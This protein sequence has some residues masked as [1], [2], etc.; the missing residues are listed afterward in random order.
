MRSSC[1]CPNSKPA[2][3]VNLIIYLIAAGAVGW[4]MTELM[5]DRP[6]LLLNIIVAIAG[7]F[8]S[9]FLLG[10]IFDVGTM[11]SAVTAQTMLVALTGSVVLLGL[12]RLVRRGMR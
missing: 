1:A 6:N 3:S 5:D 7:A 9:T 2:S 12:G 4:G 8:L 10:L 11:T